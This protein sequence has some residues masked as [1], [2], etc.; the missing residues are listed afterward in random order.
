MSRG[1]GKCG[2]LGETHSLSRSGRADYDALSVGWRVAQGGFPSSRLRTCG[3]LR[4]YPAEDAMATIRRVNYAPASASPAHNSAQDRLCDP[5][6]AP[7]DAVNRHKKSAGQVRRRKS[8]LGKT[9]TPP[10]RADSES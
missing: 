9:P 10:L 7:R 6:A 8:G 2:C 4:G 3:T 1:M 5:P